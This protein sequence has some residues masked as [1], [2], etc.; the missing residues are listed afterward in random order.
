MRQR[1]LVYGGMLLIAAGSLTAA[2][3]L[4]PADA[5]TLAALVALAAYFLLSRL[6][7]RL[8]RWRIPVSVTRECSI[9][10]PPDRAWKLLSSAE[11]WS[12]RPGHHAFDV[13]P[14]AGMP[15][16]RVIARVRSGRAGCSA[17][18]L[19]VPPAAGQ[20]GKSLIIRS[21][22][23]PAP[24]AVTLTIRVAPEGS[25]T[26]ATITARQP[27]KLGAWL[28]VKAKGGGNLADWLSECGAVL[29]GRRDWPGQAVRPDVLAALAAPLPA[30]KTVEAS[31]SVL[32]AVPP[33]RVWQ[34][35]WDPATSLALP[36]SNTV[37]A[38]F[39]PG[40]P[41]GRPGEIQYSIARS[42]RH[43]QRMLAHLQYVREFEPGRMALT[44]VTGLIGCEVLHLVELAPG[45]TRFTLTFRFTDA[46]VRRAKEKVQ[47]DTEKEVAKYKVLLEGTSAAQ[48]A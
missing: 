39:V 31:A 40:A 7:L 18:E 17:M 1:I 38:G 46:R 36:E 14:P 23:L 15:P 2:N 4:I 5:R 3:V 24:A 34:A 12:L 19:A 41:V 45:G 29:T 10:T 43:G 48:R 42:P 44:R 37:A 32:I 21:T 20:P 6:W 33:A 11:A 13:P 35:T 8:L 9:A 30:G 47:A 26:R 16:L 27:A 22:G 25:G 28:D